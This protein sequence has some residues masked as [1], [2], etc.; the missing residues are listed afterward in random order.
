MYTR[1]RGN[2]LVTGLVGL[3]LVYF[4]LGYMMKKMSFPSL[5]GDR[6]AMGPAMH[7]PQAFGY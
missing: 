2:K 6:F 3:G 5:I 4:G 1:K 7:D